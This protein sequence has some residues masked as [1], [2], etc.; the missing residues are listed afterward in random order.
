MKCFDLVVLK[1]DLKFK[2]FILIQLKLNVSG[3]LHADRFLAT[4]FT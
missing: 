4:N 1:N 2:F 3:P